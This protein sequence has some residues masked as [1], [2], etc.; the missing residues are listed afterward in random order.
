MAN[1]IPAGDKGPSGSEGPVIGENST[2]VKPPKDACT[3]AMLNHILGLGWAVVPLIG[4]VI[5]ALIIWQ[6]K[7]DQYPFV[8]QHGKEALNFQ[9]S[10]LIYGVFAGLLCFLCVGAFLIPLVIA[11]DVIFVIIAAIKAGQGEPYRYPLTIR[12]VS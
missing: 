10:M 11:A 5:G 3:W 7:K 4:G 8:D 9:I 1:E 12:F 6:I 2:F